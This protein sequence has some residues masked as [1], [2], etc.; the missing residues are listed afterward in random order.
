[1]GISFQA[2]TPD[3]AAAYN[4]PAQWDVYITKVAA[5][6]PA[7]QANLQ[8]GDILTGIGGVSLDETHS[9]INT[10]FAYKPGDQVTVEFVRNGKTNQAQ[11]TLGESNSGS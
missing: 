8:R 9:Y 4:L 6:S 1:M 11:V 7:S 10:L 2:I 3:I 5:N